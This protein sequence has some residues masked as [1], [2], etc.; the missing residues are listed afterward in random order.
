MGFLEHSEVITGNDFDVE[1]SRSQLSPALIRSVRREKRLHAGAE[2]SEATGVNA[3]CVLSQ[4]P[5]LRASDLA[6]LLGEVKQI[7]DFF[8]ELC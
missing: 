6:V 1:S 3:R 2:E 5:V 4:R 7:A 8:Y